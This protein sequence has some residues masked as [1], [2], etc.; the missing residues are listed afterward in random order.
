[1]RFTT[2]ATVRGMK[3]GKGDYEGVEY[4]YTRIYVDQ[5]LDGTKGDAIGSATEAYQI[6][7]SEAYTQFSKLPF[8]HEAEL[9]MELVT[10]GKVSKTVCV[11]YRPLVSSAS[12]PA[13]SPAQ[14]R[15]Q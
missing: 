1:M 13:K 6:G 15:E 12:Q 9:D 7:S 2:K 11:G 4:D 3:R 14:T 8:P 5:S 10:S